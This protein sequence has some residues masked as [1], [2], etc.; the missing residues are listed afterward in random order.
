MNPFSFA[1][2]HLCGA[3]LAFLMASVASAGELSVL[4]D[5]QGVGLRSADQVYRHDSRGQSLAPHP[6]VLQRAVVGQIADAGSPSPGE[7]LFWA[8]PETG[9]REAVVLGSAIPGAPLCERVRLEDGRFVQLLRVLEPARAQPGG[10]AQQPVAG[11]FEYGRGAAWDAVYKWGAVAR[12][13]DARVLTAGHRAGNSTLEALQ[14]APD[15]ESVGQP[16][17]W[18]RALAAH[19]GIE[20][21]WVVRAID[22]DA[23]SPAHFVLE[24]LLEGAVSG[25]VDLAGDLPASTSPASVPGFWLKA[26]DDG[27]VLLAA[28]RFDDPRIH[29]RRYDEAGQRI[30]SAEIDGTGLAGIAQTASGAVLAVRTSAHAGASHVLQLSADLQVRGRVELPGVYLQ[31]PLPSVE[32]GLEGTD[33]LVS[34]VPWAARHEQSSSTGSGL[35]SL[36]GLARLT[37]GPSVTMHTPLSA[38]RPRLRL[39]DGRLLATAYEGGALQAWYVPPLGSGASRLSLPAIDLYWRPVLSQAEHSQGLARLVSATD[40]TEL[41]FIEPSGGVRWRV[42]ASGD[43][44]RGADADRVCIARRAVNGICFTGMCGLYSQVTVHCFQVDDGATLPIVSFVSAGSVEKQPPSLFG[45]VAANGNLVVYD[46]RSPGLQA[47]FWET[48]Q[49]R[50]TRNGATSSRSFALPPTGPGVAPDWRGTPQQQWLQGVRGEVILAETQSTPGGRDA[51]LHRFDAAGVETTST[52]ASMRAGWVRLLGMDDSGTL[53]LHAGPAGS[54]PGVGTPQLR[55]LSAS[56]AVQWVAPLGLF[57]NWT[58]SN[59]LKGLPIVARTPDGRHW[60]ISRDARH[61]DLLDAVNGDL[62]GALRLPALDHDGGTPGWALTAG[63]AGDELVLLR[64]GQRGP[65]LRRLYADTFDVGAPARLDSAKTV[66]RRPAGVHLRGSRLFVG[67]A[68]RGDSVRTL[69]APA[70]AARLPV[71]RR[72]TGLWYD[73]VNTG[74]GLVVDVEAGSGRWFAGWFTYADSPIGSG[75]AWMERPRPV[76]FTALG[77]A[78]AGSGTPPVQGV[79]YETQG[80]DFAGTL[81]PATSDV[82]EAELRAVDCNT[83]EFSYRIRVPGAEALPTWRSGSRRM[84]RLGPPPE[85]CHGSVPSVLHALERASSGSWVLEGRSSQGVLMQVDPGAEGGLWGAW[86]GF[87]PDQDGITHRQ[88]WLTWVGRAVPDQPGVVELQ[89]MRTLGG[90]FDSHA[91]HN[92]RAIG[93]GRLRFTACDRA[94]LDYSFD[95]PGLPG[96]VFAGLQGRLQLRRF[97]ACTMP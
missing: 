11:A 65:E 83:I 64:T 42:A 8:L 46:V 77:Q 31:G 40:G 75:N 23:P 24:R 45:S 1:S 66:D 67:P 58:A 68:A 90:G 28:A 79:L 10:N 38:L 7:P 82:G 27:G 47:S 61:V 2:R 81:M 48:A 57:A 85:G 44:L 34:G 39:A 32:Q 73:P 95:A 36:F 30:A 56:L 17:P 70:R 91:T 16:L 86:F 51:H 35:D 87:V 63:E 50:A 15:C 55:A 19:P 93:T 3:L 21:G 72:H 29:V 60:A 88:H 13:A 59:A 41:Q 53:L 54:A 20:G 78:P 5:G 92:T 89:W 18:V 25:Q 33:W 97:E 4:P 26:M 37:E 6:D 74:H 12:G 43:L 96:D 22:G 69:E 9:G 52:P 49:L 62:V 84:Q 76:W 71:D 94:T 14:F 80:G